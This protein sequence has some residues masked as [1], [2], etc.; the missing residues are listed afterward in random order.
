MLYIRVRSF[1]LAKDAV[2]KHQKE[3]QMTFEA[4]ALRNK[5]QKSSIYIQF[6]CHYQILTTFSIKANT[7]VFLSKCE[8]PT[9]DLKNFISKN[10]VQS[11]SE[12]GRINKI[13][14]HQS[15]TCA[16]CSDE[17]LHLLIFD[18][19]IPNFPDIDNPLAN[20]GLRK[21]VNILF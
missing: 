12:Y 2:N 15:L 18:R 3:K 14:H 11:A 17:C 19:F 13:A 1:S 20:R 8:C 21:N 16:L 5:L 9:N 7:T 6:V 4:K 10:H